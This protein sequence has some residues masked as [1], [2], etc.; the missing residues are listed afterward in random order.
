M[1]LR[2]A[3]KTESGV[4]P[5]R[6]RKQS[7]VG[8]FCGGDWESVYWDLL[9]LKVVRCKRF[10]RVTYDLFSFSSRWSSALVFLSVFLR[11]C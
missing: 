4:D 5:R 11:L 6:D 7:M 1:G 10:H 2:G 9:V 8:S 3:G